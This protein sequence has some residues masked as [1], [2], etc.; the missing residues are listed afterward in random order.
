LAGYFSDAP[1]TDVAGI[2][3]PGADAVGGR[4]AAPDPIDD[5]DIDRRAAARELIERVR[6]RWQYLLDSMDLPMQSVRASLGSLGLSPPDNSSGTVFDRLQDRSIRV[7]W[8]SELRA[9]LAHMFVG[10]GFAPVLGECD[11]YI[12]G[13]CRDAF[14][15]RCTCTPATATSIP[16]SP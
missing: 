1:Q 10:A 2:R 11:A 5:G 7:S 12:S 4:G 15:S 6:A 9:E 16:T 14:S 8:K 3:S 13:F